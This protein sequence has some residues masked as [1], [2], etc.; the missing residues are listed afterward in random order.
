MLWK[1]HRRRITMVKKRI[2]AYGLLEGRVICIVFIDRGGRRRIISARSARNY[3]RENYEKRL[4]DR[5]NGKTDWKRI[6]GLKDADIAKAIQNDPDTFEV[7]R[8]WFEQ[9]MVLRPMQE[10]EPI[11]VRL[12][13]DML[14][15]FRTYG[16]GYQ[17]RINAIL[18]AYYEAHRGEQGR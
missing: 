15:W 12:D 9:A 6:D 8:G 11:T 1:V 14:E 16:K 10:K 4:S 18:R 2:L 5:R 7:D 17:T 3:E 13:T